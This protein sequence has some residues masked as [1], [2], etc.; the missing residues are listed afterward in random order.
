MTIQL[1]R[2]ATRMRP[3]RTP[4]TATGIMRTYVNHSATRSPWTSLRVVDSPSAIE[5]TTPI[6]APIRAAAVVHT[7]VQA[8][9]AERETLVPVLEPV[10]LVGG[11]SGGVVLA[12]SL[13]ISALLEISGQARSLPH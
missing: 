8:L 6:R 7:M 5:A 2:K 10:A 3:I 9:R 1:A 4:T 11:G 12:W 13:S